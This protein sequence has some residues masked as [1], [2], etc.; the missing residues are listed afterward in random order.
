MKVLEKVWHSR[1]IM[2]FVYLDNF[3]ILGPSK[4]TVAADVAFVLPTL[5]Q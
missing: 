2:V 1:G 3:L 5:N 4:S